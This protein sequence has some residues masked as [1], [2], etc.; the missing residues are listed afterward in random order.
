L[1]PIR[2][3]VH[4]DSAKF[5]YRKRLHCAEGPLNR[6][7]AVKLKADVLARVRQ[8]FDLQQD[9][10]SEIEIFRETAG[11]IHPAHPLLSFSLAA[12]G[13]HC[14]MMGC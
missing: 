13:A 3:V 8:T 7:E 2:K 4:H 5:D 12:H 11:Q 10:N 9:E 1:V 6:I 14:A